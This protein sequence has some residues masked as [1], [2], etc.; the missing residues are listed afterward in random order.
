MKTMAMIISMMTLITFTGMGQ[1]ADINKMMQNSKTRTE[2]YNT[3][4]NSHEYMGEFMNATNQN[5]HATMMM[6]QNNRMM[7]QNGNMPLN[8]Q[9]A[10]MNHENM[11]NGNNTGMSNGGHMMNNNQMMDQNEVMKNQ[12]QV[13]GMM[14]NQP[15]MMPGVMNNMMNYSMQDTAVYNQMVNIMAQHPKMVK[16]AEH[17]VR[18]QSMMGSDN[19]VN[20]DNSASQKK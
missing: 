3:I 6:Q 11:M 14:M 1:N 17:K 12:H 18:Q 8:H 7:N 20:K 15:A 13:M 16:L 2:I 19:A 4:M 5:K 10:N 9:Q